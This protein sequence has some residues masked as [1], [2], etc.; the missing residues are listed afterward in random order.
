M[1]VAVWYS[2]D[3]E[4]ADPILS[5][6][7]KRI[8]YIPFSSIAYISEGLERFTTDVY[9]RDGDSFLA[10]EHFEVI[11]EYWEKWYNSNHNTFI[12]ITRS[13]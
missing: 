1:R 9:M 5:K 13:N 7:Y 10:A 4:D 11:F 8:A 3:E 12:S 2:N 6:P